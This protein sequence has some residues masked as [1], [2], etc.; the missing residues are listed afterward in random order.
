MDDI[1]K[2]VKDKTG[3]SEDAAR[4]A[5]NTVVGYI[6]GKLPTPVASQIDGVIGHDLGKKT[7]GM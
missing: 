6:K 2:L 1:I 7:T 3:I 4:N 5:V